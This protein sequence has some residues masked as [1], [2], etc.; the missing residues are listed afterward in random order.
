M[1][2]HWGGWKNGVGSW[3]ATRT[4]CSCGNDCGAGK[5]E[6]CEWL[7]AGHSSHR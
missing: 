5:E 6:G 4:C 3:E 1:T 7:N 2:Y